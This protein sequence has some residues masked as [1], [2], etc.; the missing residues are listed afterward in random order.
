M[1]DPVDGAFYLIRTEDGAAWKPIEAMPQA[2]SGEAAFAA[3]G[4]C[5]IARGKKDFYIVTGGS[6]A[7]VIRSD[8][9]GRSWSASDT[10]FEKGSAGTG[11]FSIAMRDDKHGLIVGGN[12][13][14]PDR[15]ANNL[16][17]TK[18]G[19]KT[20]NLGE[21]LSGYRSAV[22]YINK[23]T[24]VT[25]GSNGSDMSIDGG[26]SW[27]RL[28]SENY[29]SVQAQGTRIWAVGPNGRI[30]RLNVKKKMM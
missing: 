19:G 7:R 9:G 12:Y 20:W 27:K 30:S 21:G 15:N 4:T 22:A 25:V 6:D 17:W 29:N 10:P 28:D 26:K 14:K 23:D 11:I 3:S 5:L 1:S 13:E 2:K 18:D 8:D 16:A 24:V